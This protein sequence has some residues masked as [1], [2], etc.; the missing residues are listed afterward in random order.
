MENTILKRAALALLF[1]LTC[2]WSTAHAVEGGRSLYLLGKRGPLAGLIPQAGWY[3][4]NDVYYY[5]ADTDQKLP[6]AGVV[7]QNVSADALA[8]ILQVTRISE[9]I[10]GDARLALGMVI[11]YAHSEVAADASATYKGIPVDAAISDDTTAFGDPAVA[12]SLGWRHRDGDLFRAWNVYGSL[13][14]PIG[15][16]EEGRLANAG[17]NRWGLDIGTGFTLG[18][19]KKGREFSGVLGMTING[20]NLDTDYQSGLEAHIELTYKQHLAS[21]LSA[22]LVGYYNYQLTKDSSGPAILGDFKGRVAAIGPE[23][24]YQFTLADRTMGLDLRWYH[25]FEAKNRVQGDSVFMTLSL[26][27]QKSEQQ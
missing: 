19:F 16:Y 12:A 20:E 14:I 7:G 18:N 26:P 5:T 8:N 9:T 24:A 27:L 3:I 21:G 10:I 11:P 23:V 4:S 22:G 2:M 17:A 15:S 6:I 1:F 13:F 25:E